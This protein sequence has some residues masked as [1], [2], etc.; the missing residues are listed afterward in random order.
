MNDYLNNYLSTHIDEKPHN[1]EV[2]NVE[3]S[4]KTIW[5]NHLLT[6]AG[7]KDQV[8]DICN[9]GFSYGEEMKYHLSIHIREKLHESEMCQKRNSKK[10]GLNNLLLTCT[11]EKPDV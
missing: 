8:C 11:C 5:N 6:L 3:L 1:Y 9:K 10:E 2:Y 7:E 4:K